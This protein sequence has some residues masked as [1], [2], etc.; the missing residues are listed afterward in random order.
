MG[1]SEYM[2]KKVLIANR[3]EIATRVMRT[4][5]E[6]NIQTV[7]VY[8]E[9][10]STSPFVQL[11]DESYLLGPSRVQESYLHVDKV[12]EIAH[13]AEVD[14]IH[15]GYGFLSENADFARRC[16]EEGFIFIGPTSE[17]IEQMGD[18]IAARKTMQKADVPVVPGTT[19]AV[20]TVEAAQDAANDIG[21]PIMLKASA[22]GGGIGMQVVKNDKELSKAFSSNSERAKNLFGDG[23]MFLEKKIENAHHVEIQLIADGKGDAIHLYDRECSIQRRNQKVI[24]EAPS[25]FI[26]EKT[27]MNMGEAAV[28]AAKTL[29]Y[30]SAGTIEFMV[31]DEEN[32]YF[33]EMNTRIQVEHPVTEEITGLDIV[34][35]QI[36]I[37]NGEGLSID[38]P[39]VSIQ[40]HAIEARIYAEDPKTFFPSPG[41]ISK[42]QLPKGENIRNEVTVENEMDVTPF[43][44]PMIGKLIVKGDTRKKAISHLKNALEAYEI[45]GIKTNIPM[46]KN[47]IE[48]E[49]FKSGHTTTAFVDDHY[50]S[51]FKQK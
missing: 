36:Q 9:A 20:E 30:T 41:H 29:Q 11:A 40:G 7:A 13:T 25:P 34:K 17:V 39:S 33:L 31:D 19:N 6:M 8:S 48:H 4:C 12:M 18:K 14:A 22:G 27:R 15:P 3:G 46:L 45:E 44:D 38:Q 1:R 5:N 37:A 16:T 49:K 47:I 43:Y 24:E 2:I 28:Q 23:S 50:L 10:D 32:F 51:Q 21:Y 26:S 42:F 35:M